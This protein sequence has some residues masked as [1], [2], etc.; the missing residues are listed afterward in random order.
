MP[1]AVLLLRYIQDVPVK[2][3]GSYSTSQPQ[4]PLSVCSSALH[5]LRNVKRISGKA[6]LK[7]MD[8]TAKL[9]N[10]CKKLSM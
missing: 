8:K 5:A 1:S 3:L 9:E 6:K 10:L 7:G 2:A 4:T